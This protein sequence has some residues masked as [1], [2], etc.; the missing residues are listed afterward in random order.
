MIKYQRIVF[1]QDDDA[2]EAITIF[3][4]KGFRAAISYLAQWYMDPPD[5]L[6]DTPAAGTEDDVYTWKG[7][8]LTV[9]TH[10]G[11]IGLEKKYK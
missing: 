11:Y 3:N 9:N 5:E 4:D 7:Y 2:S 1:L 10:F 8:I 6:F